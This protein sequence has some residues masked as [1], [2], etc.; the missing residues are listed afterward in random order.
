MKKLLSTI[1]LALVV[2]TTQEK[3]LAMADLQVNFAY[4]WMDYM[5]YRQDAVRKFG[6][7]RIEIVDSAENDAIFEE[8][9]YAPLH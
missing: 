6:G 3:E 5:M 7:Y 1:L 2:L 9:N 8:K 4:A